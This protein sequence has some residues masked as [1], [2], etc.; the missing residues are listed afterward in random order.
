MPDENWEWLEKEGRDAIL[1]Q[2]ER[3]SQAILKPIAPKYNFSA[4]AAPAVTDDIDKG[5]GVGS[6][7]VNVTTDKYY[8]CVDAT[9]GAAIWAECGSGVGPGTHELLS[10]THTD[11]TASA[12]TKGDIIAF[13]TTWDDLAVGSNGRILV[14]ASGETL[15]LKWA[16]G[17]DVTDT[18]GTWKLRAISA[19]NQAAYLWL[20]PKGSPASPFS[21]FVLYAT[22]VIADSANYEAIRLLAETGKFTIEVYSLGS[23]TDRPLY[24]DMGGVNAFYI[25][26]PA[27]GICN[28]SFNEQALIGMARVAQKSTVAGGGSGP[29]G[30]PALYGLETQGLNATGTWTIRN[31]GSVLWRGYYW[32]G[33]NTNLVMRQFLRILSVTPTYELVWLNNA[34]A[35]IMRLGSTGALYIENL[36]EMKEITTP[37]NPTAGYNRLYFKSDDLPYILDSDGNESAL[38]L[39]SADITDHGALGGLGDDDHPQY[40]HDTGNESIA[41]AKTFGDGILTDTI[42]EETATAGVKIDSSATNPTLIKDNKVYPLSTNLNSY[43]G[44]ARVNFDANDYLALVGD[45]YNFYI[46]GAVVGAISATGWAGII[47][48]LKFGAATSITLDAGGLLTPVDHTYLSVRG[49]GL[50]AD[51]LDTIAAGFAGQVILIRPGGAEDITVRHNQSAAS[52][53]NILLAGGAACLLDDTADTL[54][55]IYD[56]TLDTNGAWIEVAR[57]VAAA[58]GGDVA[59][60]PIWDVK[61]DLAVGSGADTASRLAV[62]GD[63]YPLIAKATEALGLKYAT[64]SDLV[65]VGDLLAARGGYF[66]SGAAAP[67]GVS[68]IIWAK[69]TGDLTASQDWLYLSTNGSLS[70]TQ[71]NLSF[72]YIYCGPQITGDT[73]SRVISAVTGLYF[74]PRVT[75]AVVTSVTGLNCSALLPNTLVTTWKGIAINLSSGALGPRAGSGSFYGID[76]TDIMAGNVALNAVG[77]RVA[78]PSYGTT[79]RFA[80]Q[81]TGTAK[82]RFGGEVIAPLFTQGDLKCVGSNVAEVDVRRTQKDFVE[83]KTGTGGARLIPCDHTHA[84]DI[85]YVVEIDTA[86][87][88]G[89]DTGDPSNATYKWSMDGGSTWEDTLVEL[90]VGDAVLSNG[91][92]LDMYSGDYVLGDKWE[93]TAIGTANQLYTLRA[94]TI[95]NKTYVGSRLVLAD[96][97]LFY[98]DYSPGTSDPRFVANPFGIWRYVRASDTW[99]FYA[100]SITTAFAI[101]DSVITVPPTSTLKAH[102]VTEVTP[103][104]GITVEG[105]L[106]KDGLVDGRDVSVDGAKLDAQSIADNALVTIDAADVATGEYAKFTANGLLSKTPAEVLADLSAQAAAAFAMNSQKITGLAAGSGAGDSVRYEQLPAASSTTVQGIIEVATAAETTAGADAGRAV[107]PDGL[108]GSDYGKRI[109]EWRVIDQATALT[110]GEAKDI[111]YAPIELNNWNLVR[112]EAAVDTVS[113]SGAI[114]VTLERVRLGTGAA[115]NDMLSTAITLDANE[116]TSYSAATPSVVNGSYDDLSVSSATQDTIEANIDGVGTGGKGLVLIL[117][118]QLP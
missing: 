98:L 51:N 68:P 88:G 69:L 99:L 3:L 58:G 38:G 76:I 78:S 14:P 37:A 61:G 72:R 79:T 89:V 36:L 23:G 15:G 50:A 92:S 1:Q 17:L 54:L 44:Q 8:H 80:I 62:G 34:D 48:I 73:T 65:K 101:S 2:D 110:T 19:G 97:E 10:A 70:V 84:G 113:S 66:G 109:V 22:D 108:A 25:S 55:L 47:D 12:G 75:G 27:A 94:D 4:A 6:G 52:G 45:V 43:L 64:S 31:S 117:T 102:T 59:T 39:A 29:T 118:F 33:I 42:E 20:M 100:G 86:G 83:T 114:T 60:D 7:W 18:T 96:D 87:I 41:G 103:D 24:F 5:Y 49:N 105:V 90:M 106:I 63:N 95:N 67:T 116:R 115:T 53:M 16:D 13:G 21:E 111:W 93:W 11:S 32:T 57:N 30:Q 77:L 107:S 9:K 46:G 28:I 85:D 74:T 56:T 82:S 71:P 91:V 81:T 112:A 35:D 26:P 104:A 40:V